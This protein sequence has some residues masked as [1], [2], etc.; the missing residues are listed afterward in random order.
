M[1]WNIEYTLEGKLIRELEV[2]G[3]VETLLRNVR[4]IY[5]KYE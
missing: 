3:D 2:D 1:K 5:S 4:N